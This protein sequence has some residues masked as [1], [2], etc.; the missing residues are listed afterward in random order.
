MADNN[1]PNAHI[2]AEDEARKRAR[3]TGDYTPRSNR[4]ERVIQVFSKTKQEEKIFVSPEGEQ[5][6]RPV[7]TKLARTI[8]LSFR[9]A[10]FDKVM[11]QTTYGD[12]AVTEMLPFY[13]DRCK[14]TAKGFSNEEVKD[15]VQAIIRS[16]KQYGGETYVTIQTKEL[17]SED[18]AL[19]DSIEKDEEVAAQVAQRRRA[20]ENQDPM[21]LAEGKEFSDMPPLPA[22]LGQEAGA[23][24]GVTTDMV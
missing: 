7:A 11:G 16:Q 1:K 5:I 23:L 10:R 24:A 6:R 8:I 14:S 17:S 22:I 19:R 9:I 4:K 15:A 20:V 2:V 18:L 3:E 12:E 13:S 21:K